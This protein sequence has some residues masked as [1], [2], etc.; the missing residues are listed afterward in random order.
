MSIPWSRFLVLSLLLLSGCTHTVDPKDRGTGVLYGHVTVQVLNPLDRPIEVR[1]RGILLSVWVSRPGQKRDDYFQ[2]TSD[3]EGWFYKDGLKPGE[4]RISALRAPVWQEEPYAQ[5]K[6]ELAFT[7]A[8]T[9]LGV[10]AGGIDVAPVDEALERTRFTLAEGETKYIGHMELT[11]REQ[12]FEESGSCISRP[13][14]LPGSR[15]ELYW[16]SAEVGARLCVAEK[17]EEARSWLEKRR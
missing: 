13:V 12:P 14:L 5:P 6:P 15:G 3:R 1:E 10:G 9:A 2:L 4:Y 11:F 16:S 8:E 7:V 17:S